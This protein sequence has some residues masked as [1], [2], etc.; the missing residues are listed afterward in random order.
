VKYS[1]TGQLLAIADVACGADGKPRNFINPNEPEPLLTC[2]EGAMSKAPK[3]FLGVFRLDDP[4]TGRLDR[5]L[6]KWVLDF[7]RNVTILSGLI[8]LAQKS[9]S[10]FVW[11]VAISADFALCAYCYTYIDVWRVRG[12]L[13]PRNGIR[14]KILGIFAL[15]LIQGALV[16]IFVG[17][18][19]GIDAIATAQRR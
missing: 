10:F 9:G 7:I 14:E 16:G 11:V 17:I 2:I 3:K 18:S 12:D 5:T 13:L 19:A 4:A 1:R 15:L 8:Y 6:Y